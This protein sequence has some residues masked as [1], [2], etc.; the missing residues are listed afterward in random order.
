MP[1]DRSG[2]LDRVEL[3]ATLRTFVERHFTA[4]AQV[5]ILLLLHR[6]REGWTAVGVAREL[7]FHTDQARQLL[8]ELTKGGLVDEDDGTYHYAPRTA[9]LGGSVDALA[10]FYPSFRTA[11]I[12]LIYSKP[13][14]SIRDF[15]KAF[16]LRDED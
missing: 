1:P 13:D 9:E 8:T 6:A 7:R 5:E 15:S 11:I 14:R 10:E 3:P 16:R 4:A 2:L 12:S